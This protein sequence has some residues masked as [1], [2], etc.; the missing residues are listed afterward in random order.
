MMLRQS[1]T[2]EGK[3]NSPQSTSSETHHVARS[4]NGILWPE[5]SD[6]DFLE[7]QLD[8]KGEV[9][10]FTGRLPERVIQSLPPPAA[11]WTKTPNEIG[12]SSPR[13]GTSSRNMDSWGLF[14]FSL[15]GALE[16]HRHVQREAPQV[17]AV[18]GAEFNH[19]AMYSRAPRPYPI[20][21]SPEAEFAIFDPTGKYI[22]LINRF[23]GSESHPLP[24]LDVDFVRTP[25]ETRSSAFDIGTSSISA[26]EVAPNDPTNSYLWDALEDLRDVQREAQE[27]DGVIPEVDAVRR[28][29]RALMAMYR[30]SPRPYSVYPMPDGEI[31]IDAAT[32]YGTS[33]VVLCNP[34]G[35]A[36]C[37]AY[38]DEEYRP[39]DY[40]DTEMLPD[41]FVLEALLDSTPDTA[42]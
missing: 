20:Y 14:D 42:S 22:L 17:D 33:L 9:H 18:R 37:L 8:L 19:N 25:D 24:P 36:Q 26:R 34:D 11:L 32:R 6:S 40:A 5:S 23:V 3:I 35:S 30:I 41:E 28:A 1:T 21:T 12:Y 31:V 10:L 15:W 13:T 16:D 4:A 39:K 29:G 27:D 2:T 7:T 38:I